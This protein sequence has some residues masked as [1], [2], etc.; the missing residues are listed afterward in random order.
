MEQRMASRVIAQ[1]EMGLRRLPAFQSLA[2]TGGIGLMDGRAVGASNQSGASNC[3]V[4]CKR[5]VIKLLTVA[6]DRRVG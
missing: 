1:P 5:D 2:K 3:V 4:K 6:A